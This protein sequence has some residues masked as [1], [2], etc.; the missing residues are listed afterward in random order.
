[1]LEDKEPPSLVKGIMKRPVITIDE[2]SLVYEMAKTMREEGI[3]CIVV[4]GDGKPVGIVTER[5][6]IHR[7][8]A[9]GLD[10]LKVKAQ[11]VMSKP[12]KFIHP[13]M[14][15]VN[16]IR[17]MQKGN[18]RHLPVMEKGQLLGIVTQRDLLRA[19]ALHVLISFRPLL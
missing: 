15:I 11:Q 9:E 19:L 10:P 16:A 14:P 3:G 6:I 5:D 2:E 12:L 18:V 17:E 7:V 1:M 4:M 8:V 13:N